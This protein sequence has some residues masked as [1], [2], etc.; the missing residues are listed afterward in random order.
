MQSLED[1]TA[2]MALIDLGEG[3]YGSLSGYKRARLKEQVAFVDAWY[4]PVLPH[5]L[6]Q[7]A[8]A[9][10]GHTVMRRFQARSWHI[11]LLAPEFLSAPGLIAALMPP[12]LAGSRVIII[13]VES[14]KGGLVLPESFSAAFELLGIEDVYMLP[15]H[16]NA[17]FI[18]RF[19]KL[20]AAC[21]RG[22]GD[23]GAFT[24]LG[25]SDETT[26]A[27]LPLLPVLPGIFLPGHIIFQ[28]DADI[29]PDWEYLA[30]AYGPQSCG[31]YDKHEC[32]LPVRLVASARSTQD[33]CFANYG[34]GVTL[35]ADAAHLWL[36]PQL[37]PNLYLREALSILPQRDAS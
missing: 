1:L 17:A 34:V 2:G 23:A 9:V 14:E 30:W 12:A 35:A 8:W 28:A 7:S 18:R 19:K 11:V 32:H 5:R 36:W 25:V 33:V 27:L 26:Q 10:A 31:K 3:A 22:N 6:A 21:E 15:G 20:A 24:A 29:E 13:F 37:Q 4:S 16:D